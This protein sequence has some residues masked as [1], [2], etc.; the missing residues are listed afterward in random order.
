MSGKIVLH[1]FNGRGRMEPVRWL[2][3]AAGVEFEEVF[4]TTR[5][6]Y[7]KMLE[8]GDLM[9]KQVPLVEIDGMKLVQTKAILNYI[10]GKYNLLGKDLKERAMIDMYS[11]GLRDVMDMITA[12]PFLPPEKKAAQLK[13]LEDSATGRY[14]PIYE[15]AL[16]GSQFLV[17]DKLSCADVHLMEASLML[18]EN[19][20]TILSSFPNVKAFQG[21]MKNV[22]TIKKFL[23]P[24]SKRKPPP[25]DVYVK[26]VMTVLRPQL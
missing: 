5:A 6:Q 9:F 12:L 10:A 19:L 24:G 17:G 1:Y 7:E 23:Q 25:D 15:K 8:A 14:L 18:E 26:T 13:S 22:P 16:T 3:G 11:E 4:L 20:C 21:R 2:L